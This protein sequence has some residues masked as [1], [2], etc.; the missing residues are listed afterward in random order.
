MRPVLCAFGE[1]DEDGDG[2]AVEREHLGE[3]EHQHCGEE[4]PRLRGRPAHADVA[5][6]AD[7]NARRQAR[8]THADARCQVSEAPV[9]IRISFRIS[10][11]GPRLELELESNRIA[12][13][14]YNN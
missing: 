8:Q 9:H 10:T 5:D 14:N 4:E 1:S 7:R 11:S 2:S 3:D 13:N 12:G 6:D